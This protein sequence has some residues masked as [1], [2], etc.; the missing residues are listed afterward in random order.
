[1]E[2]VLFKNKT[3][4]HEEKNQDSRDS[5]RDGCSGVGD[6]GKL[7]PSK[8]SQWEQSDS[9]K[10]QDAPLHLGG[11]RGERGDRRQWFSVCE[12]SFAKSCCFVVISSLKPLISSFNSSLC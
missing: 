7:G 9:D 1:M 12:H 4:Y 10:L 2:K 8:C 5:L 6:A 3:A 11:E